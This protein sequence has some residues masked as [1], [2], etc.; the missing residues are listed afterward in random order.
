M[1]NP[2]DIFISIAGFSRLTHL[3]FNLELYNNFSFR[4]NLYINVV[5][6]GEYNLKELI[7]INNLSC[8]NVVMLTGNEG[9]YR[10]ALDGINASLK[11]FIE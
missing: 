1:F 8:D 9:V 5:Y 10:G 7:N 3:C 4:N 6:N 11:S 2:N